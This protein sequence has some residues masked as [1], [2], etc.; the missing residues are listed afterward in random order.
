M[1]M[2]FVKVVALKK[3]KSHCFLSVPYQRDENQLKAYQLG[4]DDYI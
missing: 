4:A 2:G 3:Q 1:D